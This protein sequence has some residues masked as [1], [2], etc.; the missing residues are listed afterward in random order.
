MRWLLTFTLTAVLAPAMALG[1]GTYEVKTNGVQSAG[2]SLSITHTWS[3]S[4]N[5]LELWAWIPYPHQTSYANYWIQQPSAGSLS[6]SPPAALFQYDYGVWCKWT[7]LGNLTLTA[8]LTAAAT[9]QG[10]LPGLTADLNRGGGGDWYQATARCQANIPGLSQTMTNLETN[11]VPGTDDSNFGLIERW[12]AWERQ[13]IT[14]VA[15]HPFDQSDAATVYQNLVAACSG[16]ANLFKAG[17]IT[18]SQRFGVGLSLGATQTGT[19]HFPGP[20][21]PPG[22]LPDNGFLM[23]TSTGLHAWNVVDDGSQ[24]VPVDAYHGTIGFATLSRMS[25][26]VF[27]DESDGNTLWRYFYT[28]PRPAISYWNAVSGSAGNVGT[29]LGV[30][31]RAPYPNQWTAVHWYLAGSLK[32]AQDGPPTDVGDSPIVDTAKRNTFVV[33]PNPATI[34]N[35]VEVQV[36]LERGAHVV[37]DVFDVRGRLV[38]RVLDQDRAAGYNYFLWV[39]GEAPAG[40]YLLLTNLN[41]GEQVLKRKFALVR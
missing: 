1:G 22:Q 26:G 5:F 31:K 18:V 16:F 37:A 28:G 29:Y 30:R 40:I 41:R 36:Y 2:N 39:P 38:G 4:G 24:W 21:P 33:T 19:S 6:T 14:A 15:T 13:N 34:Q 20:P 11:V 9:V 12:S 35:W 23:T 3:V 10:N 17:L 27:E 8:T 7:N 25:D 32:P